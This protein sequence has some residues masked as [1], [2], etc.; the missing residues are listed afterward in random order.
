ML[1]DAE[2]LDRV[3]RFEQAFGPVSEDMLGVLAQASYFCWFE[4]EYAY[5]WF[6]ICRATALGKPTS[7][8][9]C[10][11]VTPQRWREVNTYVVGV[12]LWLGE[13]HALPCELDH[14]H[15]TRIDTWLGEHG[16]AKDALAQLFVCDLVVGLKSLALARLSGTGE[17][18][19]EPYADF[20]PWYSRSDGSAYSSQNHDPVVLELQSIVRREMDSAADELITGILSESQPACMHRFSRY[21]D[22]RISSIGALKW[23]GAVPPDADVPRYEARD[24]FEQKAELTGWLSGK[25]PAND[26]QR[27]LHDV[28]GQ[29]TEKKKAIIR[30]FLYGPPLAA[31]DWLGRRAEQDGLSA[32]AVFARD[33]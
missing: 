25:P 32:E 8:Q 13:D 19:D 20:T 15:L 11:Q 23:R 31:F 2:F 22:I 29:A 18:A 26:L 7:L 24:W 16:T 6:E 27:Q 33:D 21:Q 14:S 12:M 1:S 9:L 5:D 30:D 3:A 28:L 17:P 10:G 4:V